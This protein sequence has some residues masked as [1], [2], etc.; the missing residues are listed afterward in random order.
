[1]RETLD[2]VCERGRKDRTEDKCGRDKVNEIWK[3]KSNRKYKNWA[4]RI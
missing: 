1:M 3:M 4:I 2:E